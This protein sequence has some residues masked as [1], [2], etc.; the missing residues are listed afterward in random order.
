VTAAAPPQPLS[1]GAVVALAGRRPDAADAT[2]LRFPIQNAP[3]VL[4]ELRVLLHPG[5]RALVC[6]A[7][8][9]ADLLALEAAG[10]AGIERHVVL[11]FGRA[12]FRATSVVDRP[13]DWGPLYDRI[14]DELQGHGSLEL[15][16]D[17]PE[18]PGTYFRAN[19]RIVRRALELAEDPD[20]PRPRA[21]VVAWEG[22]PRGDDDATEDFRRRAEAYGFT[23]HPVH[24]L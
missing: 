23:I 3:R 5:V 19:E 7:A 4:K 17:D 24:T 18:D 9:G 13:G 15:G 2:Q 22:A 12:E 1:A 21:A 14:L 6:S 10:E 11:P 20:G 16:T 8:C